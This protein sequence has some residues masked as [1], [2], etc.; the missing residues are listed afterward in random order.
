MS[1]F[2]QIKLKCDSVAITFDVAAVHAATIQE[3]ADGFSAKPAEI[4]SPVELHAAFIQHCVDSGCS[5]SALA[6]FS[7]FCQTFDTASRDIHAIVQAQG[8]E[9]DA[10]RRVLKGYFSAWPLVNN[11]IEPSLTWPVA[12]SPA[13]F[14]SESVGLMAMFGGQRGTSSY[15]NEAAWLLDVYRPLLLDFV[16]YMSEFLHCESQDEQIAS[17]YSKGLDVLHWLT[18]ANAMPDDQY[19]LSIPVCLPLVALIQ[20]MHVMVLYKTLGVSPGD[21]VKRFK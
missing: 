13:L 5:E 17:M 7:A 11:S 6:V 18:T 12:P 3:L 14:L 1:L 16:T 8:L 20:L 2:A 21:L 19:L 9:E 10:A 15:L 4:L